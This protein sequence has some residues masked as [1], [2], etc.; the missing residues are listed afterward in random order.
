MDIFHE[1]IFTLDLN[2][3]HIF[4]ISLLSDR[5]LSSVFTFSTQLPTILSSLCLPS[6]SDI[7]PFKSYHTLRHISISIYSVKSLCP[8]TFPVD[9][10]I[11]CMTLMDMWCHLVHVQWPVNNSRLT[12]NSS[13]RETISY[14]YD[15]LARIECEPLSKHS[16]HS[17]RITNTSYRLPLGASILSPTSYYLILKTMDWCRD[18]SASVYE[19]GTV[20]LIHWHNWSIT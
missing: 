18:S 17:D 15:L 2:W 6:W 5:F 11:E 12:K 4:S 10:G 7:F 16:T 1:T 3:F 9:Y 20:K 13:Q 8:A 19:C 14:I